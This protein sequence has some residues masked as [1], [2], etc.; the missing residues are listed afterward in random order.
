MSN[1]DNFLKDVVKKIRE[2]GGDIEHPD[3]SSRYIAYLASLLKAN[4]LLD[5]DLL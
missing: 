3:L 1:P 5:D 2:V 4:S